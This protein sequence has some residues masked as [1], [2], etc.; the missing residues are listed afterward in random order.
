MDFDDIPVYVYP[1][2]FL[3]TGKCFFTCLSFFRT[4]TYS[5]IYSHMIGY[6]GDKVTNV[7]EEQV[8]KYWYSIGDA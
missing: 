6:L 7:E 8:R 2:D 5:F 1:L 4:A 3:D